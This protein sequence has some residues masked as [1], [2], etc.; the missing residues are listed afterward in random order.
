MIILISNN[1]NIV[2]DADEPIWD[3]DVDDD[4]MSSSLGTWWDISCT[5][6]VNILL[7]TAS[8]VDLLRWDK[9][10]TWMGHETEN[11]KETGQI[12]VLR[13]NG[14]KIER[15]TQFGNVD[16]DVDVNFDVDVNNVVRV[17][18]CCCYVL[19]VDSLLL[20][21]FVIWLTFVL[22]CCWLLIG[23]NVGIEDD[24]DVDVGLDDKADE[25]Y[26]WEEGMI[27]KY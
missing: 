4:M 2:L 12:G 26:D 9:L 19:C 23:V 3:V 21:L 25:E 24:V 6:C 27:D 1:F 10:T 11:E 8:L 17:C 16:D 5:C 15:V 13:W 18:V 14:G 22:Y 7:N 20:L